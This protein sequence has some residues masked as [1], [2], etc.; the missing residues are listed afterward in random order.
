[1]LIDEFL[2]DAAFLKE[3]RKKISFADQYLYFL[4]IW[5]PFLILAS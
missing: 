2:S 4:N 5:T 3:K 1:M